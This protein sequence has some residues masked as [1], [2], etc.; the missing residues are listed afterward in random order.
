MTRISLTT[1]QA[2]GMGFF[3]LYGSTAALATTLTLSAA[4][5]CIGIGFQRG[6]HTRWQ[7]VANDDTGAPTL[8]DMGAS[9]AIATGGVLTIFIAAPPNGSSVRVRV[10][11]EVSGAVF[12]QEVTADMPAKTQFLSPR[13]FMNNGA[14][15]AAV[16][17]DC[18]GVYLE[19]RS[20]RPRVVR[21][22]SCRRNTTSKRLLPSTIRETIRPF[23]SCSSCSVTAAGC[24][25]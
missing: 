17:Y 14:T 3:G 5:N 16:A 6:T 11:D 10:V 18:S 21:S 4:I 20:P 24:S 25:P 2:T 12:E 23:D 1:L 7:L 19:T 9:F 8:T 22:S 15:A 13:L